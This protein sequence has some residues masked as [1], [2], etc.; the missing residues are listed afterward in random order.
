[1]VK[2]KYDTL[3]NLPGEVLNDIRTLADHF[4]I[5]LPNINKHFSRRCWGERRF[6]EITL[7]LAIILYY[8]FILLFFYL[9][10]FMD[11]LNSIPIIESFASS[12]TSHR[13]WESTSPAPNYE[14]CPELIAIGQN[15]PFSIAEVLSFN[16]ED[17]GL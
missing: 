4:L 17:N 14:L 11:N 16:Q 5:A 7:S 9:V 15:Q 13:P 12:E 6:A 1:M 8:T 10:I 3:D 2:Y